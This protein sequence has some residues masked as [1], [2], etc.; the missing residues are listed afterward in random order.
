MI[1]MDMIGKIR[2][3]KLRKKLT[4]SEIAKVTGISRP[5]VR[6]GLSADVAGPPHY[7]RVSSQTKLSASKQ[8]L[9]PAPPQDLG[10]Q[11][12][13]TRPFAET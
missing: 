1:T 13:W 9:E 12:T 3:L 8:T 2:R 11:L 7:E 4:I 10:R 6:K 5:T